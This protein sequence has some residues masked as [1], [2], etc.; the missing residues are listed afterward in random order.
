MTIE[1]GQRTYAGRP[2]ADRLAERRRRFF[3]AAL[4]EFASVGYAKSSVTSICREAG[5]S[6]RQFYELFSDREELLVALY[7]EIQGAARD[8]VATALSESTSRDTHVLATAAMRAYMRS[9]GTCLL[10]TSP[11]PRDLST[12]RMPSSA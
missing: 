10:Y 4:G 8:A 6:R 7:D 2:V 11:S 5:L 9:V 12:S 3:D 1:P